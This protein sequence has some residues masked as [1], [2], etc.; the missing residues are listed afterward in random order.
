MAK[1]IIRPSWLQPPTG[2]LSQMVEVVLLL[3]KQEEAMARESGNA[4]GIAGKETDSE[5]EA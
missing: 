2:E 1:K 3:N 4:N 5:H